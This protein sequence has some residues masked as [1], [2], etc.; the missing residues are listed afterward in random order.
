MRQSERRRQAVVI[1]DRIGAGQA[2]EATEENVVVPKHDEQM[3][4]AFWMAEMQPLSQMYSLA[5][6]AGDASEC[7]YGGKHSYF[8]AQA[9]FGTLGM[10]GA[11]DRP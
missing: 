2:D 10:A 8:V 9:L 6:A 7:V 11:P 1:L 5:K 4:R 3:L